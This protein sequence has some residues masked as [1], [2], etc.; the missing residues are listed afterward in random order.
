MR[1]K[2]WP[3]RFVFLFLLAFVSLHF[4]YKASFTGDLL[5]LFTKLFSHPSYLLADDSHPISPT[6]I[7]HYTTGSNALTP[8]TAAVFNTGY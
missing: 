6:Q 4:T 5:T 8:Q 7:G 3:S 1:N 2:T